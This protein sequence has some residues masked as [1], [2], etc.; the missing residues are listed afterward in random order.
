L[1]ALSGRNIVLLGLVLFFFLLWYCLLYEQVNKQRAIILFTASLAFPCLLD[2]SFIQTAECAGNSGEGASSISFPR[3]EWEIALDLPANQPAPECLRV[4]MKDQLLILF[5]IGR[6][7]TLFSDSE[8]FSRHIEPLAIDSASVGFSKALL[9]RIASLQAEH[10]NGGGHHTTPF[11]F[12]T[13]KERERLYSVLWEY[14]PSKS[15]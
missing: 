1:T 15:D 11:G 10:W 8:V 7:S 3:Q 2:C 9:A 4:R 5:N 6:G 12:T 13:K 14:D